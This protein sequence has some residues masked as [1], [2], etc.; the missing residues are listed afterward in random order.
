MTSA[1]KVDVHVKYRLPRSWTYVQHGPVSLLDVSL[2]RNLSRCQVAAADHFSV[3]GLRFFQSSKMFLRDDQHMR[4][5]LWVDVLKG[6]NVLVLVNFLGGN[7]AAEDAAEQAVARGLGHGK[8]RRE[9][10]RK[11]ASGQCSVF[12]S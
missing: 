1:Q 4:G 7:L 9:H 6:E 5:S 11:V 2:A 3:F 8:L 12:R 10:N